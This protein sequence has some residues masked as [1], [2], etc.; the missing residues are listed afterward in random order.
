MRRSTSAV[1]SQPRSK[2]QRVM[3]RNSDE[4]LNQSKGNQFTYIFI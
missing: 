1:R 3:E 2:S 4:N